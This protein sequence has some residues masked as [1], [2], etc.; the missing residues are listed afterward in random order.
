MADETIAS[1]PS[2]A[3][4]PR[5]RSDS[6][7]RSSR[8]ATPEV[9][10]DASAVRYE[11]ARRPLSAVLIVMS[12]WS[13]SRCAHSCCLVV[14]SS[15][16][17]Q[18]SKPAKQ[19]HYPLAPA[20]DRP[21]CRPSRG[22]SSSTAWPGIE[23]PERLP[24]AKRSTRAMLN[25]YGPTDEEGFVHIPIERAMEYAGRPSCRSAR[26]VTTDRRGNDNGLVDAGESNSG[27]MF[28]GTTMM[29]HDHALDR[30]ALLCAACCCRRRLARADTDTAA[31][32]CE[33]VGFDQRLNE[34]VPLDLA[35]RDEAGQP[36][37]LGDYFGDKP[38]ILVLA[39]YRC[40]MLCTRCSTGWSRACSTCRSTSARTSA[41]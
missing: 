34:Q 7:S 5:R 37:K 6:A 36:V 32:A 24:P 30:R 19:S 23:T 27:R 8:R 10:I 31:G 1:R 2:R 29:Q 17:A 9:R 14:L 41:W 3:R 21:H 38:V 39:Y 26:A 18:L 33:N 35:F 12:S 28:R 15:T 22:W 20:A 4:W 16:R 40:P 11:T 25:S 13:A